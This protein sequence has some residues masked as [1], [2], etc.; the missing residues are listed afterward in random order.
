MTHG[1]CTLI[2]V[3]GDGYRHGTL[4]TSSSTAT[5]VSSGLIGSALVMHKKM[6]GALETHRARA[7]GAP[8][9]SG[10]RIGT[11]ALANAA[12]S[13]TWRWQRKDVSPED[14]Y[15]AVTY[16]RQLGAVANVPNVFPHLFAIPPELASS[17]LKGWTTDRGMYLQKK[18]IAGGFVGYGRTLTPYSEAKQV[19]MA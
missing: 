7:R 11:R 18:K 9:G 2:S 19:N 1:A 10:T 16:N 12:Q 4:P 13:I 17:V 5:S 15:E 6:E 14:Y 3:L 8:S